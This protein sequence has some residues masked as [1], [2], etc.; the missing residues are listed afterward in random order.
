MTLT[1]EKPLKQLQCMEVWGGNQFVDGGVIM[2]G[3]D[4][5]VYSRPCADADAG[6]DVH[7]VSSCGAGMVM[8]M[9]LADVSGHG[10][11]V[12]AT[13]RDLRKLMRRYINFHDQTRLVRAINRQFITLTDVGRFATAV[14]MTYEAEEKRLSLC[15]AGHPAPLH[16]RSGAGD[17]T[18]EYLQRPRDDG[19][20]EGNLPLG[21]EETEYEQIEVSAG[22][23]DLILCYTDGLTESRDENGQML[24]PAGLLDVVKAL[25]VGQPAR[26]LQD[27]WEKVAA[28]NP[29]N[30]RHDDVTMLLIRPNGIG[31]RN[32]F[33]SKLLAPFKVLG[34][35][36]GIYRPG[37]RG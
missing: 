37:A 28:L 14:A 30:L 9:L 22:V 26:L 4:A 6:G 10:Q 7:Y 11:R 3:L 31:L 15:N 13:A 35:M 23:G 25:D 34:A 32:R 18:W 8:R 33:I 21:I 12:A 5:W 27:L 24:G 17:Q 19:G 2:A 16:Y 29:G 20:G 1:A 36:T